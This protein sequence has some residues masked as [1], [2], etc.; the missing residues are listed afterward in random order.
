MGMLEHL[1]P[2]GGLTFVDRDVPT[3]DARTLQ[4]LNGAG[5][6]RLRRSVY[7]PEA[8][9]RKAGPSERHRL[10]IGAVVGTRRRPPVLSHQSA[11]VLWGIPITSPE[12]EPVHVVV[13]READTRSKNGVKVHRRTIEAA[14]ILELDGFFLTSPLRTA[15][16]L[17]R[18]LSFREAVAAL[19]FVLHPRRPRLFT[20]LKRDVLDEAVCCDPGA[21]GRER[22][23]RAIEFARDGAD[24]AGES[25]SRAIIHELGFPTPELQVRH[26]NPRGGSYYTD[27]EWPDYRVIGEFDGKGKYLKEALLGGRSPGEAVYEEKI[28]EDHLRLEG[29]QVARWGWTELQQPERLTSLLLRS[30]LP[31][32][33]RRRVG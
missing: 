17:A 28:R 7:I 18:S 22:A 14:E 15:L 19:D 25:L 4:R 2:D 32:R 31:R 10:M 11:A 29:N 33:G 23:R 21:Q 26:P 1:F 13:A 9:W 24:N 3:A 20:P 5:V 6:E 30:G 8:S 16:D 27:H 12:R